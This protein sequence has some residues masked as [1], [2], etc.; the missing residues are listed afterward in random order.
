MRFAPTALVS[1]T[2]LALAGCGGN[3]TADNVEA[4]ADQTGDNLE[5]LAE[6]AANP[7]EAE[8]LENQAILTRETG[9]N[10]AEAIRDGEVPANRQ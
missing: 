8:A 7:A 10:D 5:A 3:S 6:N 2:L 9:R 1:A 4:A